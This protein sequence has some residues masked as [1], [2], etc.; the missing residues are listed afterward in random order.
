MQKINRTALDRATLGFIDYYER[1]KLDRLFQRRNEIFEDQADGS[2][3]DSD[4]LSNARVGALQ[5]LLTNPVQ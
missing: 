5:A 2:L 3:C 1:S 4:F